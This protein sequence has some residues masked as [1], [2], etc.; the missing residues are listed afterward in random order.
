MS[1]SENLFDSLRNIF[2]TILDDPDFVFSRDAKLGQCDSWDSFAQINLIIEIE[3][4]FNVE[5]DSDQISELTSVG[6]ILNALLS[7]LDDLSEC[8]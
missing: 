8:H 1:S 7:K 5:F 4:T 3:S 2:T 6:L